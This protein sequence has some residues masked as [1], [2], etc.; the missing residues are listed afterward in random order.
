[1][2]YRPFIFWSYDYSK[3]RA[4]FCFGFGIF[5][6]YCSFLYP[7]ACITSKSVPSRSA[8]PVIFPKPQGPLSEVFSMM[9]FISFLRA[10]D[11]VLKSLFSLNSTTWTW[12]PF[13]EGNLWCVET[14]KLCSIM[15]QT[16][17][18]LSELSATRTIA[19]TYTM[20]QSRSGLLATNTNHSLK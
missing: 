11:I 15:N 2:N 5:L 16:K 6:V 17:M 3:F 13:L 19:L 14:Q 7:T 1:M 8:T 18:W 10:Y 20:A 9:S 12:L 4:V